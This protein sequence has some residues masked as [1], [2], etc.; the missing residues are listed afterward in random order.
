[1]IQVSLYISLPH[2]FL[3]VTLNQS[4]SALSV[5]MRWIPAAVSLFFSSLAFS[6][7]RVLGGIEDVDGEF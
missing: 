3:L 7:I 4:I 1:M 6:S 5:I 2:M